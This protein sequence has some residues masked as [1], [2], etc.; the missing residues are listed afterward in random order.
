MS[1][2]AVRL[3]IIINCFTSLSLP[4]ILFTRYTS[5]MGEGDTRRL[6]LDRVEEALAT[7]RETGVISYPNMRWVSRMV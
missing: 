6:A 7:A 3:V 4:T 5:N 1:A 2:P